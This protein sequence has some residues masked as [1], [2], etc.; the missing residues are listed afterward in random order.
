MCKFLAV[1][2]STGLGPSTFIMKGE[3][4]VRPHPSEGPLQ[5]VVAGGISNVT[6]GKLPVL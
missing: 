4:L 1:V 5:S 3:G 2:A 6:S